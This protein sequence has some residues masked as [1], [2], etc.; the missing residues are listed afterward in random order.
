MQ[1]AIAPY[2]YTILVETGKDAMEAIGMAPSIYDPFKPAIRRYLEQRTT[3]IAVD[4]ND[5]TEKQLRAELTQGIN[6][7]ESTHQLRAR[8][9]SV[10]GTASTQRAD[11]IAQTETTRAQAAADIE[12][13]D[14]SGVVEAKEWYTAHDERVCPWCNS[15][16]GTVVGLTENYFDKGD[17]QIVDATNRNGE[18]RTQRKVHD[19]DDVIGPPNHPRCRCTLL[20]VRIR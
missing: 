14:Q 16:N 5:E 18:K 12:A 1:K 9:E 13:W 15:M 11:L 8:V 3:K 7:G 10:F 2:I 19:Y 20:P 4:V 17:S 6:A